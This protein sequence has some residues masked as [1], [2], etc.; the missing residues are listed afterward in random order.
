MKIGFNEIKWTDSAVGLRVKT[1]ENATKKLG[2]AEFTKDFQEIDWHKK[3]SCQI[4]RSW[5]N[6]N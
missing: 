3:K 4:C 6:Q 5:Q 1:F 2:L